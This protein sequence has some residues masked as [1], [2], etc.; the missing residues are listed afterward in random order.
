VLLLLLRLIP[1][2]TG[3]PVSILLL[4]LRGCRA[5]CSLILILGSG[6]R[7]PCILVLRDWRRRTPIMMLRLRLRRRARGSRI[8]VYAGRG[9]GVLISPVLLLLGTRGIAIRS[10]PA[11][12]DRRLL[13]ILSLTAIRR[14]ALMV[15]LRRGT[16]ALVPLWLGGLLTIRRLGRGLVPLLRLTILA[17]RALTNRRRAADR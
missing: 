7:R 11:G 4:L 6:G 14:V 12:R 15:R 8:L 3:S 16:V 17:C 5:R 9:S 2:R 10:V 13:L 1:G